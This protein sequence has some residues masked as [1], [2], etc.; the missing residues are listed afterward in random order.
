VPKL[1]SQVELDRDPTWPHLAVLGIC[2]TLGATHRLTFSFWTTGVGL[3]AEPFNR[4]SFPSL[5]VRWHASV[6]P[7]P[8]T[9]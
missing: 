6:T 7:C 2:P 4:D 8:M 1:I 5:S 9:P 3:S